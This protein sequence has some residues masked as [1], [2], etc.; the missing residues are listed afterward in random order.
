MELVDWIFKNQSNL[1]SDRALIESARQFGDTRMVDILNEDQTDIVDISPAQFDMLFSIDNNIDTSN[2]LN[3]TFAQTFQ[4][5]IKI[6]DIQAPSTVASPSD[7]ALPSRTLHYKNTLP[8]MLNFPAFSSTPFHRSTI[9]DF[10]QT[11][12]SIRDTFVSQSHHSSGPFNPAKIPVTEFKSNDSTILHDVNPQFNQ[13]RTNEDLKK[14]R[15]QN[16]WEK[17]RRE[18]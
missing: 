16:E 6:S 12:S 3:V 1:S 8:S 4:G 11:P 13:S 5:N 14:L 18:E 17:M 9:A 7:I 15:R 2:S 10:C